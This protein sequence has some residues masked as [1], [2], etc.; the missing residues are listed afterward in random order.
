M[1]K[2][3]EVMKRATFTDVGN[4]LIL[5]F[6]LSNLVSKSQVSRVIKHFLTIANQMPKKSLVGLIDFTNLII[7][8]GMADELI[9]LVK[10]CSPQF[11][12]SAII[13]QSE[14]A[15]FLGNQIIDHFDRI[16]MEIFDN[17][18]RATNW[19]RNT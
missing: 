12:L 17:E 8:E 1:I 9:T 11:K 16:N 19:L 10:Q 5:K 7:E 15:V 3:S 4:V 6:D 2:L 14:E 13:A 18:A